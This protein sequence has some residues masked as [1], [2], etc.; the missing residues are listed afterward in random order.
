MSLTKRNMI[1]SQ[2]HLF[3]DAPFRP[4]DDVAKTATVKFVSVSVVLESAVPDT[5][6]GVKLTP[7][8]VRAWKWRDQVCSCITICH[9]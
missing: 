4:V 8:T 9:C 7:L 1:S 2:F 3:C 5:V 6:T